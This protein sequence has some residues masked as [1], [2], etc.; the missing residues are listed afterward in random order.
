MFSRVRLTAFAVFA[1]LATALALLAAPLPEHA[2]L[3]ALGSSGT[4]VRP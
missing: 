2:A 4:G 3:A 1:C